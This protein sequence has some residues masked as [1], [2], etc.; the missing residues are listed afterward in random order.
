MINVYAKRVRLCIKCFRGSLTHRNYIRVT[1]RARATKAVVTVLPLRDG[2]RAPDLWDAF[3][4]LDMYDMDAPQDVT[5]SVNALCNLF[6]HS[7]ALLL[8]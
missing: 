5:I 8:A 2:A 6:V 3:G 4:N 7:L 1:K